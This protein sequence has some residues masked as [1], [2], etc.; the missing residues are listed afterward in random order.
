MKDPDLAKQLHADA[1]ALAF[2]H[3]CAQLSEERLDVPPLDI[4]RGRV[5]KQRREGLGLLA[6]HGL[7]D[8]KI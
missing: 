3:R 8:I 6:L 1:R 2:A 4:G 5:R 7:N